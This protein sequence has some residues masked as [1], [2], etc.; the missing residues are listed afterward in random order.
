M[1]ALRWA[2]I[3]YNSQFSY[4]TM[5]DSLSRLSTISKIGN[6]ENI[7]PLEDMLIHEPIEIQFSVTFACLEVNKVKKLKRK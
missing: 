4:F 6:R 7:L 3:Q 2:S 1:L 5:R